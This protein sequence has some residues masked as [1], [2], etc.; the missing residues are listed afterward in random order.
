MVEKADSGVSY[1]VKAFSKECVYGQD[2]GKVSYNKNILN[3]DEFIKMGDILK[4][5]WLFKRKKAIYF[6]TPKQ[7]EIKIS[8]MLSFSLLLCLN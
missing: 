5:F 4:I 7:L 2:K 3:F 1:A 6:F 8:I